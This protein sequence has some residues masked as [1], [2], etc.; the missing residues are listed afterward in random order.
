MSELDTRH[1]TRTLS[2]EHTRNTTL[3]IIHRL[4]KTPANSCVCADAPRERRFDPQDC[5]QARHSPAAGNRR[6]KTRTINGVSAARTG[7]DDDA[8]RA[9]AKN[10]AGEVCAS[11]R[12]DFAIVAAAS[13]R[14]THHT[15]LHAP[16]GRRTPARARHGLA[17]AGGDF[18]A[19][20]AWTLANVP[21]PAAR[22]RLGGLWMFRSAVRR[23]RRTNAC[24]ALPPT[25][26]AAPKR[27]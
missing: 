5:P 18:F 17:H 6:Q 26:F 7:L 25:A 20:Q 13:L 27:G 1:L 12:H 11:S 2:D 15:P 24:S 4:W 22:R 9:G 3:P 16:F 8:T 19:R 14:R 10:K 21:G 23:R